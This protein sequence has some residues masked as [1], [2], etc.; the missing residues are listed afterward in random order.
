MN[1]VKSTHGPERER[2][3]GSAMNVVMCRRGLRGMGVGSCLLPG[4][5]QEVRPGPHLIT[6][7]A[8]SRQASMRRLSIGQKVGR[9]AVAH[10]VARDELEIT[11]GIEP[12]TR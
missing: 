9:I 3:V 8:L 4:S 5:W 12:V 10:A 2:A 11:G 6:N 7:A 1:R